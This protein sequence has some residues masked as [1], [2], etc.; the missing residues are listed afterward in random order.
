MFTNIA[1]KLGR[2]DLLINNVGNFLYKS[3]NKTTNS[4]FIDIIESNV[5]S[6]L[7][8]SREA[9][10][11]MRRQKSGHIINIGAVGAEKSTLREKKR[12]LFH[13]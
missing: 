9:L 3:F 8:C 11:L 6:T 12:V 2:I 1:Q 13:C 10:I 5:Y 4:Q 7:F